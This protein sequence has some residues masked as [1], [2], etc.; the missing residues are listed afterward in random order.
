MRE[1]EGKFTYWTLLETERAPVLQAALQ[2]LHHKA[3]VSM[4]EKVG[5]QSSCDV[6]Y[7]FAALFLNGFSKL[8]E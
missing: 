5:R 7:S 2:W 1:L 4:L 6:S 8:G 3:T